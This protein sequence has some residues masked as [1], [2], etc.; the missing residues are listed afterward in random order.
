MFPGRLRLL[1]PWHAVAAAVVAAATGTATGLTSS[2]AIAPAATPEH[3]SPW[4][5]LHA[6][7][8]AAVLTALAD[9]GNAKSGSADQPLQ[10]PDP[11]KLARLGSWLRQKGADISLLEFKQS[12]VG[13]N[14]H[15]VGVRD[16]AC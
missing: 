11:V 14:V 2:S 6:A 5:R 1:A 16:E 9:T 3:R 12:Q 15:A 10:H 7:M 13:G 8:P 4:D